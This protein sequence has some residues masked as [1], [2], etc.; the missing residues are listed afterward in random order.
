M[1]GSS[2]PDVAMGRAA[3]RSG[4]GCGREDEECAWDLCVVLLGGENG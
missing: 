4:W 2:G 1:A 3:C